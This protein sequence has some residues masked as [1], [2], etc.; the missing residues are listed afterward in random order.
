MSARTPQSWPAADALRLLRDSADALVFGRLA[1]AAL[2][3]IAGGIVGAV[4]PLALKDMV[5]VAARLPQASGPAGSTGLLFPALGYL[6]ALAI[7]RA[8]AEIRPLFAG[9]AEQR[10]NARLTTRCFRHLLSLP[11]AWHAARRSGA[12]V[13]VIRQGTTGAQVLL[14]NLVNVAAPV[15]VELATI[16]AVMVHLGQGAIVLAFVAAAVGYAA[17]VAAGARGLRSRAAQVSVT[18]QGVQSGLTEGLQLCETLKCCNASPQA[19]RRLSSGAD[20]LEA[21]WTALHRQRA[22]IGFGAAAVFAIA[23]MAAIL[24]AVRAVVDGRLSVG[25]FVLANVYL[26]QI[27]RPLESLASSARDVV[28]ALAWLRPLVDLMSVPPEPG[29]QGLS[30]PTPAGAGSR[31]PG[32]SAP[33]LSLRNVSFGYGPS[34]KVLEDLSFD[35][36]GGRLVG[37]VG[38][39]GCGKSTLTRLLL[40]LYEP[41]GG[42]ILVD[43]RPLAEIP[44][45]AWR[46]QVGLVPQDI[47]L[48]DDSIA[49]NIALAQPDVP[50]EAVEYASRLASLHDVVARLPDGY[51]TVV[52]ERGMCLSGGERQRIALA[53]AILRC[54]RLYLLDEATSMLDTA[55]EATLLQTLREVTAGCTTLVVAHRLSSIAHADE[56]IVL[57]RG[58]VAERGTHVELLAAEGAYARLWRHQHPRP[59]GEPQ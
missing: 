44:L 16:T 58:R 6:V 49:A 22:R 23:V 31:S 3:V 48:F 55:T 47:V 40:R 32:G 25:G 17:V 50:R 59:G 20:A 24:L 51:D 4:A 8:L 29:T 33:S 12:V 57:D 15:L 13:Q 35:V 1:A 11:M 46:G 2:T 7:A 43:G 30:G 21:A 10:L 36:E 27:L 34:G 37:I 53:R 9:A 41:D 19:V 45:I 54:P 18:S 52:G 28:Q 26:L 14:A 56:I 39:S 42:Q 38:A 5:D